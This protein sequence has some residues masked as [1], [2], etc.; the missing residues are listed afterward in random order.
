MADP[1]DARCVAL[2]SSMRAYRHVAI[3][4]LIACGAFLVNRA[5]LD[6]SLFGFDCYAAI[7]TSRI[8][9]FS[10][11][12]GTFTEVLMDGRLWAADFYRPV[13]NL[14]LAADWAAWGMES[15]GYQ[16][17]SLLVWCGA[18]VVLYLLLRRMLGGE[19]WVGPTAA[20]L[21]FALHPS[22]LAVLPFPARRTETLML[23][24]VALALLLLPVNPRK[25]AWK[26]HLLAGVFAM[27]AVG[28]KETGVIAV[29][30]I[31]LHQALFDPRDDLGRRVVAACLA[32]V[33]AAVL[34]AL[35]V[36]TRSR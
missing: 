12:T 6:A 22:A 16:L 30:L 8:L 13:G 10:D 27:L 25:D 31:F 1:A 11:F 23:L 15:A 21:F 36:I 18:I 3:P 4:L 9:S 20:A 5:V 17:T 29:A 35:V 28:S 24:F 33:P 2:I 19:R 32:A 14:F 7:L 26:S 34:A